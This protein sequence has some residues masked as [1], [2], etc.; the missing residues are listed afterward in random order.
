LIVQVYNY[1]S[2]CFLLINLI[3]IIIVDW[4]L[5]EVATL[6]KMTSIRIKVLVSQIISYCLIGNFNYEKVLKLAADNA[7][8]IL[9]IKGAIAAVHFMITNAAKHDLDEL[10]FVQEIQQLG[11]P[12]ENSDAIARQFRD[13]KD[14][15]RSSLAK[16]SYRISKLLSTD[17][18]VD[19]VIATGSTDNTTNTKNDTIIQINLVVD[20]EPQNSNSINSKQNLNHS[21]IQNVSFELTS[22][23]LDI[24]VHE[25]SHAKTILENVES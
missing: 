14:A 9:D 16:D 20:T 25:L 4:V 22:D 15:L 19:H 23:K 21:N 11:L 8:G 7:E 1:Y 2:S 18:R 3:I 5:A 13:N 10:S 17:W 6:S 12:K 24:L